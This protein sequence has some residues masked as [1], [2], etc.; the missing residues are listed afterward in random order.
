MSQFDQDVLD[1][2][3]SLRQAGG[4]IDW[5]GVVLNFKLLLF[6]RSDVNVSVYMIIAVNI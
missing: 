5:G 6:I 3:K 1:T 4:V 2:V